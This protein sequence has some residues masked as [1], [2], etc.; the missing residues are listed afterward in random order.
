MRKWHIE[1]HT[2]CGEVLV[3]YSWGDRIQFG[4]FFVMFNLHE[5]LALVVSLLFGLES[6]AKT[7]RLLFIMHHRHLGMHNNISFKDNPNNATFLRWA[8]LPN[9]P[10]TT[11]REQPGLALN[12]PPPPPKKK[13]KKKRPICF[14]GVL[15][16]F[17]PIMYFPPIM[18]I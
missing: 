9:P 10:S 13:K 3:Y 16:V 17:T 18:L 14:F 5:E 1:G 6:H 8:L 15:L 4:C 2:V 12:P 11:S 7:M